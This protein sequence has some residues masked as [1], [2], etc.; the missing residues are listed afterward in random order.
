VTYIPHHLTFILGPGVAARFHCRCKY[1]TLCTVHF[2]LFHQ[3][4]I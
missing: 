3:V 1:K 2:K 4:P